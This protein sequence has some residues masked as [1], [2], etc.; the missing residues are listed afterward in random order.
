MNRSI[1]PRG[2]D[3]IKGFETFVPFVYDDRRAPIKG[4]YREWK[5]EKPV[6]TLTIGY[7]HTDQAAHP[8]KISKGLRITEAKA[9]EVLDVDLDECEAAV[10]RLVRVDLTQ[11]QYDALVSFTFNC[12]TGA[13]SKS[14]ILRK[15]NAGDYDGARAALDL[16]VKC[17]GQ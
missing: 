7:G 11:G 6:G 12:G 3:F 1:S 8:L 14:S 10:N 17:G 5:G 4:K 16:Y 2:L 13:L 15:L 9:R